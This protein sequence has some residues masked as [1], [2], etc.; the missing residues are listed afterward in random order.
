MLPHA[1]VAAWL[2]LGAPVQASVVLRVSARHS[3]AKSAHTLGSGCPSRRLRRAGVQTGNVS[4][5]PVGDMPADFG[6]DL[7]PE[8]LV[9]PLAVRVC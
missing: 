1:L 5:D 9:A 2:L 4:F 8:G 3:L 6:P 7:P